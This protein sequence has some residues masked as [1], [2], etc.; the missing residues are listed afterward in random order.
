M[1]NFSAY[2]KAFLT[3]VPVTIALTCA[4]T[5]ILPTATYAQDGGGQM[6]VQA[7]GAGIDDLLALLA[8]PDLEGWE[9]VE[10]KVRV[11]WAR[12]GSH[13][14]DLLLQRTQEALE[15]GETQAALEHATA[16]TD[17]APEFA[18]GWNTLAMAYFQARYYGPAL[19]ALQRA[20][21]LNPSHFEALSGVGTILSEMGDEEAALKAFQASEAIHP[22]R[23]HISAAIEEL[24]ARMGGENI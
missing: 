13:S 22:H 15:A 14:V 2:L 11:E 5:P 7:R 8:T 10:A 17:H 18:E 4:I 21:A 9:D 23:A 16:M 19:D 24:E 6:V 1:V 20:I 3:A 12:S